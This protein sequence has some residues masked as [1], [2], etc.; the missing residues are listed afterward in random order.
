[1]F[2]DVVEAGDF[3]D[4]RID[5]AMP[6]RQPL[7]RP[8]LRYM[9]QAIGPVVVFGASNFPLAFSVAGGDTAS[10]FAAGCPVLVKGH[11]SHPGHQRANGPSD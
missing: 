8:D 7:P 4:V 3:L 5:T 1:M 11:S 9:N 10:A 6:D 2:A